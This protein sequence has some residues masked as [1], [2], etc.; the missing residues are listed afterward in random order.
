MKIEGDFST[1]EKFSFT[2]VQENDLFAEQTGY[3]IEDLDP[4]AGDALC[5]EDGPVHNGILAIAVDDPYVWFGTYR[6][7][8]RLDK[9]TGIW[10]TFTEYHGP[11][12][13]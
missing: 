8:S 5:R 1:D 12:D 10:T 3:D 11:E 2:L 7:L 6:G 9:R 13:L 4:A